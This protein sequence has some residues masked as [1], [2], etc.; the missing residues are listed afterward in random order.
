[1]KT[2]HFLQ[3]V[4]IGI[5]PSQFSLFIF[6]GVHRAQG[7]GGTIHRVKLREDHFLV[8]DGDV[9]T[10]KPQQAE[11]VPHAA[12]PVPGDLHQF[13]GGGEGQQLKQPGVDGFRQAVAQ[14]FPDEA[15]K[16]QGQPS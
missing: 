6:N 1:M 12:Q 10:P 9:D 3:P 16:F 14:L 8:G 15:E 7:L 5:V 11:G 2:E 4:N 13:I